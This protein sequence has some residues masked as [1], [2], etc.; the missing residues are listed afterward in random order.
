MRKVSEVAIRSAARR[1]VRKSRGEQE[2]SRIANAIT[3]AAMG[4]F[5]IYEKESQVVLWALSAC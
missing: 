1:R 2:V 5:R 3:R 4:G